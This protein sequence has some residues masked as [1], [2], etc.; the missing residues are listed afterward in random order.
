MEMP[1]VTYV[2]R[3]DENPG[4]YVGVALD[5]LVAW[6][7][8]EGATADELRERLDESIERAEEE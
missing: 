6:A 7:M 5:E 2:R 8:S 1:S 3:S 4:Y